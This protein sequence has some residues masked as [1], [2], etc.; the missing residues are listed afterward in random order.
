MNAG[1]PKKAFSMER[2][3]EWSKGLESKDGQA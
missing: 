3:W 1:V 2:F